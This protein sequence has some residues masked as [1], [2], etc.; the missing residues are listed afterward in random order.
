MDFCDKCGEDINLLEPCIKLKYGFVNED[1]SF[2]EMGFLHL[3]VDCLS[4]D[5]ALSK[6]L[7]NFEK[8]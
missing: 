7:E 3:H 4:D 5:A 8:N 1:T 6:I 2:T